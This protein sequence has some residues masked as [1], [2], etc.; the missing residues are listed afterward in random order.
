VPT[1]AVS[2]PSGNARMPL[3]TSSRGDIH[4]GVGMSLYFARLH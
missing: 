2:L 4:S 1:N 3:A